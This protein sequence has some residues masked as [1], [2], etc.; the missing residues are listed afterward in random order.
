MLESPKHGC[1]GVNGADTSPFACNALDCC[2]RDAAENEKAA[3]D[4]DE[5]DD[6]AEAEDDGGRRRLLLS[7]SEMII[8]WRGVGDLRPGVR[9]GVTEA[10]VDANG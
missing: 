10:A 2:A 5:A 3:D 1:A 4:G 7:I 9:T 8:E 6:E